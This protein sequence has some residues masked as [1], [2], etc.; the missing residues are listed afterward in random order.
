MPGFGDA[1][2]G[3]VFPF[4]VYGLWFWEVGGRVCSG[5]LVC[6]VRRWRMPSCDV[7]GWGEGRSLASLVNGVFFL[8]LF[9]L[10]LFFGF[11]AATRGREASRGEVC[12]LGGVRMVV[13]VL[14]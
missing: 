9:V 13:V 3:V 12:G 10:V 7:I 4:F 11:F 1:S 8:L 2:S 5:G 14:G 6:E